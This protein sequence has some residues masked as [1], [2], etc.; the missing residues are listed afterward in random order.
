[1][2]DVRGA[3]RAGGGIGS[4]CGVGSGRGGGT[5][6]AFARGVGSGAERR[7]KRTIGSSQKCRV[8]VEQGVIGVR[9]GGVR[10]TKCGRPCVGVEQQKAIY[11][12]RMLCVDGFGRESHQPEKAYEYES[13]R[14][15]R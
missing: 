7:Y 6:V 10:T 15:Y 1:M 8:D 2:I 5:G 13:S 12:L 9:D 11:T 3:E 14:G 4:N